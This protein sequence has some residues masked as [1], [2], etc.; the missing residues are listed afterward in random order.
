MLTK[1]DIPKKEPNISIGIILPEDNQKSVKIFSAEQNKLYSIE[2]QNQQLLVNNK[3]E[4]DLCLRNTDNNSIFIVEPVSAGRGFHWE[5]KIKLKLPGSLKIIV[6]NHALFVINDLKLETYLMCVATSEMSGL[7]PSSFLEAQTIAARSWIIAADEQ[8][9]LEMGIDAC[10]DDCCQRYQG[11]GNT[12]SKSKLAV[13]NSRGLFLTFKE[14]ICDSRYS[15][16]CGGVSENNENVWNEKPKGYLRAR[17]DGEDSSIP[18]FKNPEAIQKWFT[19]QPDCYCNNTY[20]NNQELKKYIGK[21]DNQGNYFRWECHYTAPDLTDLVNKKT[22]KLFDIVTSIT[23]LKR[24]VSG[25]IIKLEIEGLIEK[26]HQKILLES[27]YEIR[28]VLHQTFLYSSAFLIVET[29][30][31]KN[32]LTQ[33]KLKGAGWGHGV[34]LCQIGGLG[35]A[36]K[37]KSA[38]EILSH[39]FH[40]STLEKLYD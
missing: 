10:N 14:Q 2:V 1:G 12:T 39:Y 27:E 9:H 7:C 3:F 21:V 20:V 4:K 16:S 6:H 19:S 34:G 36:L 8:K 11:I 24:G 30:D 29:F 33:I 5:K 13:Q 22:G 25:R 17:Y 28:R 40:S 32:Q 23:P 35:M 31:K 15:K 38:Y 18:N 26:K 37:N